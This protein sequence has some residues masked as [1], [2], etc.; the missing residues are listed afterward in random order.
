MTTLNN[1]AIWIGLP[2][3][4]GWLKKQSVKLK[5]RHLAR[6]T[7][8]ELSMLNDRE[9]NDMGIH[10]GMIRNLAE[11]HYNDMVNKNLRGWV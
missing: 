6:K 8:N 9:L 1:T 3:I 5:A 7:V 10:R 11:E 4:A 2:S